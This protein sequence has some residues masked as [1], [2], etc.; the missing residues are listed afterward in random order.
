M[1]AH[2]SSSSTISHPHSTS[3]E[4]TMNSRP[5][6]KTPLLSAAIETPIIAEDVIVQ[7]DPPVPRRNYSS[8]N[9]KIR[10]FRDLIDE[11]ENIKKDDFELYRSCHQKRMTWTILIFAVVTLAVTGGFLTLNLLLTKDQED[12]MNHLGHVN[13]TLNLNAEFPEITPSCTLN[14]TISDDV[15]ALVT[16]SKACSDNAN[17]HWL[18]GLSENCEQAID[19][20]FNVIIKRR[21]CDSNFAGF[22]VGNVLI[23]GVMLVAALCC[24]VPLIVNFIEDFNNTKQR[25]EKESFG[26]RIYDYI[27][28]EDKYWLLRLNQF[29]THYDFTLKVTNETKIDSVIKV[30]KSILDKDEKRL[31]LFALNSGIKNN[32]PWGFF[33]ANDASGDLRDAIYKQADLGDVYQFRLSGNSGSK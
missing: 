10:D 33:S 18:N 5:S 31:K 32:N 14:A 21:I 28:F 22:G 7:I 6:E 24:F 11:L 27:S 30:L 15:R 16:S 9:E 1:I 25:F 29:S 23:S 13:D 12:L 2:A 3:E 8:L 4:K 17:Q 20:L 26:K 19:T